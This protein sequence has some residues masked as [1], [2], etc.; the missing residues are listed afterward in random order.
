MVSL[1]NNAG[2][3]FNHVLF[4]MPPCKVLDIMLRDITL[5]LKD[6]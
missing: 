3:A 5:I 6:C 4:L 2:L 1:L